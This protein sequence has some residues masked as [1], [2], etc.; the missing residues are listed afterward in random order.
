MDNISGEINCEF[1][2]KKFYKDTYVGATLQLNISWSRCSLIWDNS[3]KE[4]PAGSMKIN[5][6][7]VCGRKLEE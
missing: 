4:Y 5:Y 3:A 7:P 1:C 6:C 2:T